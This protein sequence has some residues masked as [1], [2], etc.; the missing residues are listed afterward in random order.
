MYKYVHTF[1][2]SPPLSSL[3]FIFLSGG[4]FFFL[5]LMLS[6]SRVSFVPG[7]GASSD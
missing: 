1:G 7:Q 6:D 2:L 5:P 3:S 4:P